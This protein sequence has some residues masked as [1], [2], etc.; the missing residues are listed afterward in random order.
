MA[1]RDASGGTGAHGWLAETAVFG[2][3]GRQIPPKTFRGCSRKPQRWPGNPVIIGDNPWEKWTAYLN[4]R[5]ILYDD[6]DRL[7]KTVV[8]LP[9]LR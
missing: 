8:S 7:F 2:R 3:L 5:G 6:D 1:V 9:D 4:G